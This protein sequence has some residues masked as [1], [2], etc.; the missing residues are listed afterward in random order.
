[1][2]T[3]AV[4]IAKLEFY[5]NLRK[6]ADVGED[7]LTTVFPA[8]FVH[9]PKIDAEFIQQLCAE[10]L[11]TRRDRNGFPVREWQKMR[12][13]NEALDC[14]VYARAAAS[15]AGLDRFEERHWRTG[16]TTGGRPP[17][18]EPP[19][20]H[21][22]IN[23][24]TQRGGLAV[25]G[26]RNTGRRVIKSRWLPDPLQPRRKHES[27][28]PYRKPG[29]P[30]RAGVQRRPR[31]GRQPRQP[32]HHRQVESGRGH[33][34]TE[35]RRGV[36]HRHRRCQIATTSTYSSNKIVSLLDALKTEILVVPM[37][38]TTPWWKSSN[39][40]RTAPAVWTLLAAVNNRVRF[41]AAQTLT[42]TEQLQ[43]RT[44]IGAVAAADVGNTDTDFVASLKG[45]WPDEPRIRIA[46]LAARIGSR[47]RPRSTPPIPA[48]RAW[49]CFGYVGGQVVIAARTTWPACAHGGGPLPRAFCGGD[50]GCELLL[51]GARA[52]QHQQRQQRWPSCAP[53]PTK[54]AQ[55]VD[56][57]CATTAA[58]FDD[59]INLVV[60]R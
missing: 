55:Y 18:D 40:C 39:C 52:Q 5:N 1:V 47:S 59:E 11:I 24:A 23:E 15:A 35:G 58:S 34:R 60:Y 19:P 9:L 12:E 50:A 8:G 13:R 6:S 31:Q 46:A 36:R 49:V 42:V 26:N 53:A 30:R 20:H 54:T 27:C 38:P 43:A 29:H 7:G 37:P 28:Y 41:D 14:Y 25:S 51:D 57:S 10:Q 17:P 32:H 22:S 56:I 48:G 45:R 33:Q 21:E 3:V 4:G 44:N 16:A 2:F